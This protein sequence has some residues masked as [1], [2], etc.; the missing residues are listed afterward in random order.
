MTGFGQSIKAELGQQDVAVYECDCGAR[1]TFP[2]RKWDALEYTARKLEADSIPAFIDAN[3]GCC[4]SPSYTAARPIG[5][6]NDE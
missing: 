4:D 3:R 2:E 6:E 5:G 1:I